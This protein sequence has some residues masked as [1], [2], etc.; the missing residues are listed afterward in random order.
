MQHVH[1]WGLIP[2][3]KRN[4]SQNEIGDMPSFSYLIVFF[5][6]SQQASKADQR[7]GAL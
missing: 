3:N 7:H 6:K 2:L 4:R 5:I 1:F